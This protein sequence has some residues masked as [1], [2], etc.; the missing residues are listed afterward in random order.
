[1]N[2]INYINFDDEEDKNNT[3]QTD[4]P[5]LSP[6]QRS[7]GT[8]FFK[9][10]GNGY[11]ESDIVIFGA[12]F[13]GT[14]SYRPGA[15]FAPAAI[16]NES[17][18]IETYSPY[19]DADLDDINI[20][21]GGD[22]NFAPKNTESVLNQIEAYTETI[23]NDNKLPVML[24]GEQL[25]TLGAVRAAY[26][27]YP[28]LCIVHFGA[29]AGMRDV[30]LGGKLSHATIMRRCHDLLGDRRIFQFGIRSGGKE[31]FVF[32]KNHNFIN[33]F[34]FN[35]LGEVLNILSGREL[36][37]YFTLDLDILDPAD[38]PGT[39]TP[40]AGGVNFKD[41][42][43]AVIDVCDLNIIG[44]DITELCP[45]YDPSGRSTGLACRILR[46]ILLAL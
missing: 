45:P 20:Y 24:G 34:D 44:A 29:H 35:N 22:L 26:K 16:R 3:A 43:E 4:A 42:L 8:N 28:E 11:N 15:R 10:C 41:L 46:E 13:D 33:R 9:G 25:I 18:S 23:F 12:P 30:Y 5:F 36:P 21:D 37:V 38:L 40:E 32:S 1:M 7:G 27:K 14:A 6:V 19:L 31:E 39:G 2:E 17:Y